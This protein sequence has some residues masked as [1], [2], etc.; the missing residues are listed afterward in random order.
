MSLQMDCIQVSGSSF[1][2]VLGGMGMCE[3]V[4]DSVINLWLTGQGR[5]TNIAA[6]SNP[7]G[8]NSIE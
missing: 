7:E 4:G 5:D 3:G 1:A 8:D 2:C 6:S